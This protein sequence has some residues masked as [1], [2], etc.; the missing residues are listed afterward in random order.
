MVASVMADGAAIWSHLT[1]CV[2]EGGGLVVTSPGWPV[3]TAITVQHFVVGL[4][5]FISLIS[6]H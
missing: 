5:E 6:V 1:K 3:V 4:T 2:V